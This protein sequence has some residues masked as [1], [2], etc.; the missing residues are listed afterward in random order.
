LIDGDVFLAYLN[1][2]SVGRFFIEFLRPDAW[3]FGPIAAAQVFTAVTA[4]GSV[5]WM[6]LR[7]YGPGS[8]A[9]AGDP[10]AR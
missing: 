3:M 8:R 4:I 6:A 9:Q 5:V 7:Y 10:A 2:Y 1:W